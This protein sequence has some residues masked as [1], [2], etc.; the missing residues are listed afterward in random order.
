MLESYEY[1]KYKNYYVIFN[2]P[3]VVIGVPDDE[4]FE[5]AYL[6]LVTPLYELSGCIHAGYSLIDNWLITENPEILRSVLPIVIYL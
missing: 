5:G 2:V 1:F 3:A 4:D 6:C